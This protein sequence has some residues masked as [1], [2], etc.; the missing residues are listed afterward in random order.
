MYTRSLDSPVVRDEV[1]CLLCDVVSGPRTLSEDEHF[2]NLHEGILVDVA[3]RVDVLF[4]NLFA[5]WW[6]VGGAL[7]DTG[8]GLV[9]IRSDAAVSTCFNE[10]NPL[11]TSRFVAA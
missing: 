7:L 10:S 3:V 8:P 5:S 4:S 11:Q 6:D 9:V 2:R 1:D